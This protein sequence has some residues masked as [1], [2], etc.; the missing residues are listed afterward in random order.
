MRGVRAVDPRK[1]VALAV[2][3]S[4]PVLLIASSCSAT[5]E[6]AADDHERVLLAQFEEE[7]EAAAAEEEGAAAEKQEG[8]EA[9]E[10][11][12]AEAEEQEGAEAEE[13][14]G[15][16]AA[17]QVEE[18][19][20][21]VAPVFDFETDELSAHW[22]CFGQEA[23]CAITREVGQARAG[24]GALLLTYMAAEGNVPGVSVRPVESGPAYASLELCIKTDELSSIR[25]AVVEEDGSEYENYIACPGGEWLDVAIAL[26][27]MMLAQQ[28]EDENGVLDLEQI[29]A[30][31]LMDLCNLPGEMG[32]ALGI[33]DGLQHLWLDNV[34]LSRTAAPMRSSRQPDGTIVVDDFDDSFVLGLP[35]GGAEMQFVAGGPGG[36]DATALQ[37]RYRLGGH[38]WV[39]LVHGVA[40]L[41]LAGTETFEMSLNAQHRARLV[42]VLEERDGSKYET[43]IELDPEA[44]WTQVSL[45]IEQF[46][47]DPTTDD[48]NREVD[49]DQLRVIILVVDTFNASVDPA[50]YG[51]MSIG[52]IAFR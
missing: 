10:Q 48:E 17:E 38:R 7:Q 23:Q 2:C 12:G 1:L 44:G 21:P 13:Q 3:L 11:E 9:E 36:A 24:Q 28:S 46:I 6:G 15:A 31:T 22:T 35:I 50:G 45:P 4:I 30:M 18:E 26:D 51:G 27:E 25:V 39:G 40:H 37:V 52:R 41:D 5:A 42:A 8:A 19:L 14:E 32:R 34:M 16:E 43:N 33:K 29:V 20:P 49:L 47:L